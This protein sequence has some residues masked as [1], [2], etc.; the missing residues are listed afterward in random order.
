DPKLMDILKKLRQ[1][2]ASAQGVPAYFI[3][4]DSTLADMCEKRPCSA[5]E[6][7]NVSGVGSA[8]LERYGDEFMGA[9]KDYCDE[10]PVAEPTVKKAPVNRLKTPEDR[11]RAFAELERGISNFVPSEENVHVTALVSSIIT[12]AEANISAANLRTA[13]YDWLIDRGYLQICR[14]DDGGEHKGITERSAEIGIFEQQVTASSGK[15]YTRVLYS[16]RAQR[17]IAD[18]MGNIGKCHL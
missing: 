3:F 14:D 17:F 5:A 8:K 12:A 16:T 10:N 18:N 7:L 13:V 2:I 1:K 6:F 9:I 4:T 11:K 15:S